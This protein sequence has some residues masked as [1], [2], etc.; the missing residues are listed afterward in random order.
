MAVKK[1]VS[2]SN[3]LFGIF[4]FVCMLKYFCWNPFRQKYLYYPIYRKTI[5]LFLNLW[6]KYFHAQKGFN[7]CY[8]E[9]FKNIEKKRLH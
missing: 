4:Y 5:I 6:W 8:A 1:G 7:I 9:T 2:L 3:N